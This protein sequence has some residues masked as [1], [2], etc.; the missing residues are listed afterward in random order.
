MR[1]STIKC[2][3]YNYSLDAGV[4]NFLQFDGLLNLS[5]DGKKLVITLKKYCETPIH[6]LQPDPHTVKKQ[7]EQHKKTVRRN[8][9]VLHKTIAEK[10]DAGEADAA[11]K[12]KIFDEALPDR[13]SAHSFEAEDLDASEEED[14]ERPEFDEGA[15]VTRIKDRYKFTESSTTCRIS[16]I[17]GIIFGGF[18]SRFW[19]YRKHLCCLDYDILMK[20]TK[21]KKFRGGKTE[22]PFYA[23]QCIT[24]ELG[25]RQVDL[26]IKDQKMMDLFIRFLIFS[27]NTMDCRKDSA[28]NY[29]KGAAMFEL[30][31][32]KKGLRRAARARGTWK[33]A[34]LEVPKETEAQIEHRWRKKIY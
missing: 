5:E 26:V 17:Q 10:G 34:D 12:R 3:K 28:E 23:W 2:V 15:E 16:D 4:Q 24:L 14:E 33:R 21:K 30:K 9:A 6:V 27:I 18:S 29:V 11:E 22:L 19:I 32:L 13:H 1:A 8:T 7:R 31:T 20:D 25:E